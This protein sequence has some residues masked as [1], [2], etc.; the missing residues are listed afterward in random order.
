[1][2]IS[3]QHNTEY[4]VKC[5]YYWTLNVLKYDSVDKE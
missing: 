5:T 4:Q 2:S 1:M 3:D